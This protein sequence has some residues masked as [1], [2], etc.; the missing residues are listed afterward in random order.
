MIGKLKL[1]GFSEDTLL[2]FKSY[3]AGRSQYVDVSGGISLRKSIP[4]G[5][6]QG[7]VA[8]PLLFIIYINDIERLEERDCSVF[9]YA[10]DNNYGVKLGNN[11]TANQARVNEKLVDVETYMNANK[12][13]LNAGKTQIM[14]MTPARNKINSNL[15]VNFNGHNIVPEE[16]AKF[17]GLVISD[18]LSWDKYIL[19]DQKSLLSFLN[20]KLS[21]L[22][23][24]SKWC[25]SSQLLLLA[26]GMIISKIT[27]CISAWAN[28]KQ[29]LK[30][31]I[32]NILTETYRIVY[33]DRKSSV[34][35]L[36]QRAKALT[37]DGWISY[38]DFF[39]GKNIP[40][41]SHL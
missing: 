39:V 28:C 21:A 15:T 40:H 12:L 7:S 22:R 24:M 26:N 16:S 1:Y 4:V 34:K 18:N 41:R 5:V 8:G 17:L 6:F 29:F 19:E 25:D 30:D 33:N 38:L 14:V 11:V 9:V 31:K 27:Y 37:L 32:Q 13:K 2:W 3:L 20:K 36:F 23:K 10:D 35:D